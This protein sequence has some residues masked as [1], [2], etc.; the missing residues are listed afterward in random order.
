MK[1]KTPLLLII[2][3]SLII[4]L[5]IFI[6]EQFFSSDID[7][8]TINSANDLKRAMN[9]SSSYRRNLG[10]F[11]KIACLPF[12]LPFSIYNYG[13]SSSYQQ[14]T[15]PT[16]SASPRL[17]AVNVSA[18]S[19]SLSVS[20]PTESV[21]FSNDFSA[22]N[23]QVENVDE[24]DIVKTDG[25]Y[26]Y[27][28]ADNQVVITQT[29]PNGKL[30]ILSKLPSAHIPQDLLLYQDQLIV[31][32]YLNLGRDRY[33]SS[34]KATIVEIYDLTNRRQPR[35]QKEFQI[36]QNYYSSRLTNGRL[37]LITDSYLSNY[38]NEDVILPKYVVDHQAQT[39]PYKSI[40]Y[41]VKQPSNQLTTITT[42][43]LEDL[44][45]SPKLDAYLMPIDNLYVSTNSLYLVFEHYRSFNDS[46]SLSSEI[47]TL[48]SWGG[49]PG[50]FWS[51]NQPRAA[52]RSS[53]TKTAIVKLD[54]I[55]R[56]V[57]YKAHNSIV[58]NTLNQFS[59]DEYQGNL[60]VALSE[61]TRFSKI[62]VFS[63]DMKEIGSLSDIAPGEKIYSTR[64]V[65]DR[66]YMVTFKTIDPLFVIDLKNPKQPKI[67]GELKIPGY[68]TYL[69]PYDENHIIGIG[70]D[71]QERIQKDDFGRVIS[72]N[73]TITGMKMAIFDVTDVNNPKEKFVQKIGDRQT[74]SSVLKNHKALLFSKEKEL[75]AIPVHNYS[76]PITMPVSS[77]MNDQ[78]NLIDRL[79]SSFTHGYLVY[80]LNLQTGFTPKGLI[81]HGEARS[82]NQY[83]SDQHQGSGEIRGLYIDNILYTLSAKQIKS[84]QLNN[85]LPVA[86]VDI[87]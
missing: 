44:E 72:E 50:F 32:S 40:N 69:H 47:K 35:K 16:L 81:T 56:G 8:K 53:G 10:L 25:R 36:E 64:F 63:P 62:I 57:K 61:G 37:Y 4:A 55:N 45:Q 19:P 29:D 7:F 70:H 15:A 14:V 52:N 65:G 82:S 54:L 39:L 46:S 30:E 73:F 5:T 31:I 17:D 9:A 79:G 66:A 76:Q 24:A 41:L 43:D 58:G 34:S 49:I 68:S 12:S 11:T 59:M 51:K 26:L 3:F 1:N 67:L 28:V 80:Q 13:F 2:G 84:N 83:Y 42:F 21:A 6:R 75:L 22:T 23:I 77:S 20:K 38:D 60:R 74:Y 85:L 18:M 48:F 71:T 27:S 87:K 86:S 33:Y 78:L